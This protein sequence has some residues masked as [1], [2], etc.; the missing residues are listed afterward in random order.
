MNHGKEMFYSHVSLPEDYPIGF[1][2]IWD[3]S[4]WQ[5]V[6]TSS[7]WWIMVIHDL[8]NPWWLGDLPCLGNTYMRQICMYIYI[9]YN[10][11]ICMCICTYIYIYVHVYIYIYVYIYI[12]MYIYI[13]ICMYVC[14][15]YIYI[16]IP[17]IIPV[18]PHE[19]KGT[20]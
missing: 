5:V 20:G 1:V 14:T 9:V 6:H 17:V 15:L 10:I 12:C 18:Y 19:P 4:A 11:Y 8:V 2:E 3:D 7:Y 16:Y 13:Y